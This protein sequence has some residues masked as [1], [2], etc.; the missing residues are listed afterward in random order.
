MN[1][2]R[3]EY[4]EEG[5]TEGRKTKVPQSRVL[6]MRQFEIEI[7]IF[8]FPVIWH[9]R[10]DG[11]KRGYSLLP[12]GSGFRPWIE[13][14]GLGLVLS[15]TVVITFLIAKPYLNIESIGASIRAV[16]LNSWSMLIPAILFWV[17][18]KF[19]LFDLI[20]AFF[21]ANSGMD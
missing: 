8:G 18:I 6:G 4:I 3:S 7:W 20:S 16:G 9:V 13:G 10:M 2:K 11:G 15:V 21:F 14:F 12:Q 5:M 19:I 17:F 1:A